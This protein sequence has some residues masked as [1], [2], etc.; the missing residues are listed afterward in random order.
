[1]A[2]VNLTR[3][4]H[5]IL[6]QDLESWKEQEKETDNWSKFDFMIAG[7]SSFLIRSDATLLVLDLHGKDGAYDCILQMIKI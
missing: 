7:Y 6:H 3:L 1:M 2:T 5:D 4:T